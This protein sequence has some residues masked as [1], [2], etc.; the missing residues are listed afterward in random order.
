MRRM[1][2]VSFAAFA[3]VAGAAAL[4]FAV[5]LAPANAQTTAASAQSFIAENVQKGLAILS[6]ASLSQAD[7]RGQFETLLLSITD[8]DRTADF[9]LGSYRK[10]APGADVSAFISQ[11]QN[12][13]I[14]VYQSYF[15]RYQGE[16]LKVTGAVA[17][18][19]GDVVVSTVLIDPHAA[20]GEAP[21]QIDF[22]VMDENGKPMI[23]D[24][25]VAGIWLAQEERDQFTAFLSQHGASIPA[26]TEHL[27]Q[28][29]AQY[30]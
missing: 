5:L 8:L 28:I 26:L 20:N 11:F 1:W 13:A 23:V 19:P 7:R 14:A 16:T 29:E 6:D 2:N 17:H 3:R 30:K 22:R 27:K 25:S 12:Y 4:V 24:F 18:A 9:T 10:T 15:A 21:L